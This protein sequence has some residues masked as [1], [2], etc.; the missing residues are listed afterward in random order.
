[1]RLGFGFSVAALLLASGASVSHAQ[2]TYAPQYYGNVPAPGAAGSPG[3]A[4]KDEPLVS[5]NRSY[6]GYSNLV[7][8]GPGSLS[9]FQPRPTQPTPAPGG[10]APVRRGFRLFGWRRGY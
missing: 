2:G 9:P 7:Y 8:R 6:L 4:F 1:M 10:Y 5:V 3:Y